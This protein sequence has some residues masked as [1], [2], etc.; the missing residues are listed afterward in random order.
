MLR[1]SSELAAAI[2]QKIPRS[3]FAVGVV[4]RSET[5]LNTSLDTKS[6]AAIRRL[7]ELVADL[8]AVQEHEKQLVTNMDLHSEDPEALAEPPLLAKP[9]SL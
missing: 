8:Q 3:T 2:D 9:A 4:N 7:R 1:R 5:P 6:A